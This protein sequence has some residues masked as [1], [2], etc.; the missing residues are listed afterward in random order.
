MGGPLTGH[1][2]VPR[3]RGAPKEPSPKKEVFNEDLGRE[4]GGFPSISGTIGS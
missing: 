2:L 4:A 1:T 3:N